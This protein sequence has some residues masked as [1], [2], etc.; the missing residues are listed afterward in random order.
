M[1][2][3]KQQSPDRNEDLALFEVTWGNFSDEVRTCLEED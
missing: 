1:A 3:D 2:V